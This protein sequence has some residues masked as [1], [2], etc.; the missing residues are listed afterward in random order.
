MSS[1]IVSVNDEFNL[2]KIFFFSGTF[3]VL[4]LEQDFYSPNEPIPYC[5][6]L[7]QYKQ[8]NE[9]DFNT[10]LSPYF[11]ILLFSRQVYC[12]TLLAVVF[13][14]SFS[15]LNNLQHTMFLSR[16]LLALA[17]KTLKADRLANIFSSL[18]STSHFC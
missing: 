14:T 3:S 16:S 15:N 18:R 17:C 11:N 8:E 9:P 1:Y 5:L 2:H 4:L 6:N 12:F 10:I 7:K 13:F